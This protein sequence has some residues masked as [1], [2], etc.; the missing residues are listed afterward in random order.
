MGRTGETKLYKKCNCK[1]FSGKFYL[2]FKNIRYLWDAIDF[3]T[4]AM[5]SSKALQ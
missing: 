1:L 3:K 4:H 5:A 2:S